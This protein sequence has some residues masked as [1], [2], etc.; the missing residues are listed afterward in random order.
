[1][2]QRVY[3]TY[4]LTSVD[5]K[6]VYVGRASGFGSPYDVMMRRFSSHE[7]IAKGFGNPR[8]DVYAK[9][10]DARAA[11]RGREQQLIDYYGGIGNPKLANKIRGVSKGNRMGIYY[12]YMSNRY[13]GN[14]A[15]YTGY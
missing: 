8:L 10:L 6:Q 3:V 5:G 14:I 13:F 2:T 11:I 15:P 9:G 12:H 1:M 7:M 4:I